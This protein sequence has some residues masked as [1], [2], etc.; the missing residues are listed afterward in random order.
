M[1]ATNRYKL[2]TGIQDWGGGNRLNCIMNNAMTLE[3]SMFV[4]SGSGAELSNFSSCDVY[5]MSNCSGIKVSSSQIVITPTSSSTFSFTLTNLGS[6]E[7]INGFALAALGTNDITVSLVKY[8]IGETVNNEKG[9]CTS[10]LVN[11]L[12]PQKPNGYSPY[13]QGD[14]RGYCH[15]A[16]GSV[17]LYA[18]N[19]KTV[20]FSDTYNFYGCATKNQ[21][22]YSNV[23]VEI[24]LDGSSLGYATKS[25][26]TNQYIEYLTGNYTNGNFRTSIKSCV[27]IGSYYNGSSWVELTRSTNSV[28]FLGT[29]TIST[30]HYL[31]IQTVIS[32]LYFDFEAINQTSGS[33]TFLLR[34]R[35]VTRSSGWITTA[36][37]S[38]SANTTTNLTGLL[39]MGVANYVG[40][41]FDAEYSTD[42]GSTW[43]TLTIDFAKTLNYD[44]TI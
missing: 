25:L 35:N 26:S 13:L 30:L 41:Y 28:T 4:D 22:N 32:R 18:P 21:I 33:L 12:S 42:G 14:F 29:P 40:D 8:T 5:N 16:S 39:L 44:W 36:G 19:T 23:K 10:G 24:L 1:S 11:Q 2:K 34:V 27:T 3:P 38:V 31:T 20:N 6:D 7:T 37:T 15:N 17:N 9:L 43:T